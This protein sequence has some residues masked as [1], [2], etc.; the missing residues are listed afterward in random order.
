MSRVLAASAR[1]ASSRFS[2]DQIGDGGLLKPFGDDGQQG[3]DAW[4]F[5]IVY[6]DKQS[7]VKLLTERR[8][9]LEYFADRFKGFAKNMVVLKGGM[10]ETPAQDCFGKI[11]VNP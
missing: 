8:E 7:R 1:P 10:G 6:F 4:M 5:H 11:G 3:I 9:H 2:R